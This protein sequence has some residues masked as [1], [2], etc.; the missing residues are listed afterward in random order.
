MGVVV[1]TG[2]ARGIGRGIALRLAEDGHDVAVADLPAMRAQTDA[3]AEEISGFALDVDV[4]DA[5]QVDAMIASVVSRYGR[6]DVM[7]ANAGIAQVA[8]LLDVTPYCAHS[9]AHRRHRDVGADRLRARRAHGPPEGRGAR[10]VL[11]ADHARAGRDARGRG[12]VR[13]LPGLRGLGLQIDGGV[14]FA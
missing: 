5:G 11:R 2:G 1:V 7:V 4:S 14:L 13:L 3:T 10:A 8:P 12:E 6:L 9:C